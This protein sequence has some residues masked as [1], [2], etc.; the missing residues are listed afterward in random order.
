ML[1][2]GRRWR[3]GKRNYR[4]PLPTTYHHSYICRFTSPSLHRIHLYIMSIPQSMKAVILKESYKVVVE[5]VLTPTIREDGDVLVKIH[6]AGLCGT[7]PSTL[8]SALSD[9]SG[10]DL[11][12]YRGTE[13]PA[14]GFTLGHELLGEVVEVGKGIKRFKQ[15]DLVIAPFSLSCGMSTISHLTALS[16][17]KIR[18]M[19]LLRNGLYITMRQINL[20][21]LPRYRGCS[22]RI[23]QNTSRRFLSIPRRER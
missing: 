17:I 21:R 23:H 4:C 9:S 5:D 1:C 18:T 3:S 6:L 22:S 14:T 12:F 10:S 11:H 19:L 16:L 8:L 20:P 2:V 13:G 15:G 7:L